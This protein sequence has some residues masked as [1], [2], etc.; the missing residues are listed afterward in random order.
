MKYPGFEILAEESKNAAC[1]AAQ[2]S[3]TANAEDRD[4][5]DEFNQKAAEI[6]DLM[7]T[8]FRTACVLAKHEQE[9]EEVAA[10][11]KRTT[12]ICDSVC[13]CMQEL[14]EKFSA[15]TEL[16]Y[17]RVLDFRNAANERYLLHS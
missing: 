9:L 3:R 7:E 6:E 11:W 1:L 12:E 8:I 16:S 13:T 2:S 5:C 14:S 10:I 17:D 4:T 15:C